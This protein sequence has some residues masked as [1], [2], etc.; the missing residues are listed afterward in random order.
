MI[1]TT[2]QQTA[3]DNIK[4]WIDDPDSPPY[5]TL[6]GYAGTGKTTLLDYVVQYASR[7]AKL[8]TTVT[9]PTNKAVKVLRE[10]V[11][12]HEF[13]TIHAA[14][15]IRPKRIG[16]KEVFEPAQ[17]GDM[18][19]TS[20]EFVVIDEASMVSIDLLRIIEDKR[21]A[22][23]KVLFCG[24]P[25]QLQPVNETVSQCFNFNPETL[26]EVVRHG[27][28]IANKAALVRNP[29]AYVSISELLSPPDIIHVQRQGT[30]DLFKNWR[31]NP[32][33]A[34]LL[35]WTN[36]AAIAWNKIL[37]NHDWGRVI[38]EPFVEG[39]IVIAN[40]PCLGMGKG[41]SKLILMMNSEEGEVLEVK[42]QFDGHELKV[43]REDGKIV[44]LRVV[45]AKYA[46]T[47]NEMLEDYAS[48]K[49]WRQFWE[50]KEQFHDVRLAYAMTV[51]K[52]QGSTFQNVVVDFKDISSNYDRA[53]KNQLL[54]VAMTR[55]AQT[56][57]F[58]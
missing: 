10:K 9:A 17:Y 13:S 19:I 7:K 49:Y 48:R 36:A 35:C 32:D 14:L 39:D 50:L 47:V 21:N 26:H 52:S 12:H 31:S 18:P 33:H 16:T 11:E 41:N 38:E 20:F 43:R 54:Y 22:N 1:L 8:K 6:M 25:A 56:V 30:L 2:D 4:T 28:V 3:L 27:D 37:R 53:N 51:H 23:T 42:E 40:E 5:K 34:R 58:V 55:A 29:K 24:D 46:E 45:S 57:R 44:L 15:S